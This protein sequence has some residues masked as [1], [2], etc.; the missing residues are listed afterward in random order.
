MERAK[1]RLI[2]SPVMKYPAASKRSLFPFLFFIDSDV[3][4]EN[5]DF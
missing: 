5:N 1:E 2:V 3:E 4:S